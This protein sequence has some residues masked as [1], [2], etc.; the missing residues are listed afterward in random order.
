VIA[1]FGHRWR[2]AEPAAILDRGSVLLDTP[3]PVALAG[4][5]FAG[6]RV[7]GAVLS[8]LAAAAAIIERVA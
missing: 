2:F 7:E 6:A 1:A 3:V 8:G 5:V 4:E